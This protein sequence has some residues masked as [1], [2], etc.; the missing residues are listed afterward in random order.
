MTE[1]NITR[2][3]RGYQAFSERDVDSVLEF[4]H[5]D[6]EVHDSPELPDRRVWHGHEGLLENIRNIREV[7]EAWR[8]EPEEFMDAGDK[9]L[10]VVRVSGHGAGSGVTVDDRL[11]HLWT[12][13]GG[14]AV[15]LENYRDW[16]QALKA[17]GLARRDPPPRRAAGDPSSSS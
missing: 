1:D 16:N 3:R 6:I 2:V 13:A 7:V 17:A 5:P 10:V 14:R 9:V 8:L 12:L 11:L 15:R 4:V